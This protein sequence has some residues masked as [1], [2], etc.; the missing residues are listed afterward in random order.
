MFGISDLNTALN[1]SVLDL[2][3]NL[4]LATA[5]SFVLAWH[6][7]SFGRALSNRREFAYVIPFVCLT[8]VLIIS[9]VKS[10]LALSL[11]LVGALSIV[12]FRTPVKEPEELAYLFMAIAAGLGFGADQ[13][14]P[15]IAAVVFILGVLTIR[16]NVA[17]KPKNQTH[18][19]NVE[20][21]A[22][23]ESESLIKKL[24]EVIS[25]SS[26]SAE[27]KRVDARDAKISATFYI[28]C[29]DKEELF[30]LMENLRGNFPESKISLI[31]RNPSE[32]I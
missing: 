16:A 25:K 26:A 1:L 4:L 27:V 15:T 21:P 3:I 29:R 10:S 2:L 11:G 7:T 23:G 19:L 8:T 20:I 28:D 22:G 9:I 13:R 17:Y 32:G 18:F 14:I 12:R 6:Y 24:D 5:V 31:Q 30:R